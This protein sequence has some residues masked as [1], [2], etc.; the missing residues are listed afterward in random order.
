MKEYWY[1]REGDFLPEKIETL[2]DNW[3][4]SRKTIIEFL[5]QNG[6]IFQSRKSAD[7]ASQAVRN[8]LIAHQAQIGRLSGI[9]IDVDN[10][11]C[12]GY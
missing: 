5:S 3:K 4:R 12:V 9:H 2:C 7:M 11:E 8:T 10:P 1:L 6:N